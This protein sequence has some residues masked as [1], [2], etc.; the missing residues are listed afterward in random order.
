MLKRTIY[1]DKNLEIIRQMRD[2]GL[3]S[4][5][6]FFCTAKDSNRSSHFIRSQFN[7]IGYSKSTVRL[8]LRE[9]KQYDWAY[10]T[11]SG[12]II[13]R[14]Y[15]KVAESYG[16]SLKIKQRKIYKGDTLKETVARASAV[17]VINNIHFQ[18]IHLIKGDKARYK[19]KFAQSYTDGVCLSVEY[20]TQLLGFKTKSSGS[21]YFSF[22]ENK[23]KL[24]ARDEQRQMFIGN[25]KNVGIDVLRELPNAYLSK[26]GGIYEC[27]CKRIKVLK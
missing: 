12:K 9:L 3:L 11:K 8:R 13:L 4:L 26:K 5:W 20:L 25:V 18:Q 15:K 6:Q 16:V 10:T 23:L 1:T 21:N 22:M 24:I 27:Y 7:D 17:Y 14:S 19:A 2:N